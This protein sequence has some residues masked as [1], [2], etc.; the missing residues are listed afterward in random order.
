MSAL[1]RTTM[2]NV[3]SD[4]KE[5]ELFTAWWIKNVHEPFIHSINENGLEVSVQDWLSKYPENYR[6]RMLSLLK[7]VDLFETQHYGYEAFPKVELQFTD[8]EVDLKDTEYNTVKERQI[9]GPPEEKKLAVNAFINALEKFASK[10]VRGYCGDKNWTQICSFLEE[11]ESLFSKPKWAAMDG[12][13]FDITVKRWITRLMDDLILATLDTSN[14]TLDPILH[15]EKIRS[16]LK[17]SELLKISVGRGAVTY[18]AE[19]RASGDG[20]TTFSNS[21]IML[22]L[23]KYCMYKGGI[24]KYLA[25]AKGD[26]ALCCV[27]EEMIMDYVGAVDKVFAKKNESTVHGL[28]FIAKYVK[29][30]SLTELDFISN[31]FFRDSKGGYRMTRIPARIIQTLPWS[32]KIPN[33]I[34]QDKKIKLSKELC[35]SKGMCLLSW[36]RGLPIW[37][38]LALKLVHLGVEGKASEYNKYADEARVWGNVDDRENYIQYLDERYNL[39]TID[40]HNIERSIDAI[41]SIFEVVKIPELESFY[42]D[43]Y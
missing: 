22:A 18:Q 30:G 35:F 17:D 6:N 19:G 15:K 36:S 20:W 25:V 7:S 8:V 41:D 26:D 21:M 29:I 13:C 42:H 27:E 31:H 11:E 5:R 32:T 40:V 43:N 33:S 12:S 38:K 28:G 34:S 37:E 2:L 16:V 24:E 3:Q 10:H 23:Q 1:L 4:P 9:C 39:S 14:I